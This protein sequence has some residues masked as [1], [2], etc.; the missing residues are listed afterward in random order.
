MMTFSCLKLNNLPS[1]HAKDSCIIFILFLC[2]I[3]Q[4]LP[5]S[6]MFFYAPCPLIDRAPQNDT[7]SLTTY[8]THTQI[9]DANINIYIIYIYI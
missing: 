9:S 4:S 1:V 7:T 8:T 5:A 2:N 6:R 3:Q